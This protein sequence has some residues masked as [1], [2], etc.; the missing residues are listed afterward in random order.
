MSNTEL[1][2]CPF[3]GG[4][5]ILK[6][7]KIYAYDTKFRVDWHV[8]C[9][10]CKLTQDEYSSEYQMYSNEQVLRI[11]NEDGRQKVIDNWNRRA[12]E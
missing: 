9:L 4:T 10:K 3:C 11:S 8:K 2:P 5:A 6:M 1:K 7:S 12:N